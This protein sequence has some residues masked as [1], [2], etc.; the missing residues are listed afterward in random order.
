MTFSDFL[1]DEVTNAD[2]SG[3][4]DLL[5]DQSRII[6][7]SLFADLFVIDGA[8]AIHMLEVSAASIKKIAGSEGEFRQRCVGDSEGWLLKPLAE[9]CRSVGKMPTAN[10]CY[11]FTTLPLFGGKYDVEN[12]WLCSWVEWLQYTAAVYAQTRN[13]PD[14]AKVK[15]IV[16]MPH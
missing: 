14:G 7:A 1:S 9:R 5:P 8:G 15:V 6:A 16:Q 2:L 13:L 3:W 12:I 10:Q 4:S 11:A